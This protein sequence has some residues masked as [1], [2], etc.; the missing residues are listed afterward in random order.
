MAITRDSQARGQVV[1][2]KHC[3]A[4]HQG[5][6]GG[7]GPSLLQLAPGPIVR[8]QIRAG[9]GVMPGFSRNEISNREMNDL[10]AY[11]RAS[12]LSGPPFRPLR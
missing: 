12:R 1:Y 2:M 4:C 5:G 10:I 9:L 8:T 3:Y 6:E 7:L 11:I